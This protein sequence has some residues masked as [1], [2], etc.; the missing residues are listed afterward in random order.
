MPKRDRSSVPMILLATSQSSALESSPI[1]SPGRKSSPNSMTQ[2]VTK[3]DHK[4][5]MHKEVYSTQQ[6][7]INSC[8]S[9]IVSLD[10]TN[11]VIHS[12]FEEKLN[13]TIHNTK[14]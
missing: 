11:K 6:K 13:K 4:I 1:A 10:Q 8:I 5:V 7:D 9:N 2:T 3:L 12:C 14:Q